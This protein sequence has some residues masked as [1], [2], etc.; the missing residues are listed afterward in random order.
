MMSSPQYEKLADLRRTD[1]A[2]YDEAR[3]KILGGRGPRTVDECSQIIR[4]IENAMR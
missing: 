1:R 2:L 3:S 4:Y